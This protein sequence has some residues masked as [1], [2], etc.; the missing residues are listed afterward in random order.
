MYMLCLFLL[1]VMLHVMSRQEKA[2]GWHGLL[3]VNADCSGDKESGSHHGSET[4]TACN[5]LAVG[6]MTVSSKS[7]AGHN[8]CVTDQSSVVAVPAENKRLIRPATEGKATI[9]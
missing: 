9:A 8:R 1:S 5:R 7:V 3:S 6:N 2:T 4:G